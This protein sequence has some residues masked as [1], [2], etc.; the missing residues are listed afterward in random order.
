MGDMEITVTTNGPLRV[1]G[2]N[3]VI[4][5]ASGNVFDLSGREAVSLCRCGHSRNKPFCDG[6]HKQQN[7]QSECPARK[8]PPPQPK[9]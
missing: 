4:K 1:T 2:K 8:L 6:A 9:G 3:I 5:D 7:F